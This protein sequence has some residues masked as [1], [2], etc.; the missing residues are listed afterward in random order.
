MEIRQR[1]LI[2]SL[3]TRATGTAH[4]RKQNER[5]VSG[6]SANTV[7]ITQLYTGLFLMY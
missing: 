1:A 4:T 2:V 3:S 6:N 5:Q 7:A